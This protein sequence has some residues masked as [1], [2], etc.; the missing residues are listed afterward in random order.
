V[1]PLP[2]TDGPNAPFWAGARA[3]EL[4]LQRCLDCGAWRFPAAPLCPRCRSARAEWARASGHG[5]VESFCVF[6]RAYFD[7]FELPYAVIQVRLE[8]GAQ[9]FSNLV[10]TPPES[11]R[12]G[13]AVEAVFER[14]TDEVT[15]VK[16]RAGGDGA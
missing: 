8:E 3:G 6:H 2:R 12:I 9:L 7:G 10:G 1:T 13:M 15:L 5:T 14:A 4:R 11:I 16:F